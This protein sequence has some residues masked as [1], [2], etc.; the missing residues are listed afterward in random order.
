MNHETFKQL[1]HFT[2]RKINIPL[3]GWGYIL[4]ILNLLLYLREQ[5]KRKQIKAENIQTI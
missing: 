5:N 3:L 4:P 2:Q 1:I